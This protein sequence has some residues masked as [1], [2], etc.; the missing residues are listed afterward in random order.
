MDVVT[1]CAL[2][3][4]LDSSSILA[5]LMLD[6]ERAAMCR[7]DLAVQ[8]MT[9]RMAVNSGL[10]TRPQPTWGEEVGSWEVEAMDLQEELEEAHE[11]IAALED[12]I[13]GEV[14][15][16]QGLEARLAA[17]QQELHE[18]RAENLTLRTRAT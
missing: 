2:A 10:S 12:R 11:E 6:L 17:T 18:A 13:E 9:G 4:V 3:V 15:C 5:D 7:E 14:M 16:W 8:G 1:A